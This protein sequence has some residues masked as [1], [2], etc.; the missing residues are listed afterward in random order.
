MEAAEAEVG[1]HLHL[2]AAVV[3][4]ALLTNLHLVVVWVVVAVV[5]VLAAAALQHLL[6]QAAV[7]VEEVPAETQVLLVVEL[8]VCQ[9]GIPVGVRPAARGVLQGGVGLSLRLEQPGTKNE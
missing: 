3:E 9:V 2:Q 1:D 7:V 5:V 4:A 8:G 6:P